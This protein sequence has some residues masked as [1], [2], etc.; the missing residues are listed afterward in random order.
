MLA[1]LIAG[2]MLVCMGILRL[3]I[4][5]RFIPYPVITG[6]TTGLATIIV[7]LQIKEF[8]GFTINNHSNEVFIG[9]GQYIEACST[10][11]AVTCAIS[12]MTLAV[13]IWIRNVQ[14]KIPGSIIAL[15]LATTITYFFDLPVATIN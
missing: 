9:I 6:F 3:G 15:L 10:L 12:L 14:P 7:V 13:I 4:L 11:N 1:T 5:I 8:C 2:I